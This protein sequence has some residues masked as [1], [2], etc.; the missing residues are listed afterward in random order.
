MIFF[1][2]INVRKEYVSLKA[3][4]IKFINNL[5]VEQ[6]KAVTETSSHY[7]VAEE[8]L[9]RVQP[10]IDFDQNVAC[11]DNVW[12]VIWYKTWFLVPIEF[13]F[14][15]CGKQRNWPWNGFFF[16][17]VTKTHYPYRRAYMNWLRSLLKNLKSQESLHCSLPSCSSLVLYISEWNRY[18][19]SYPLMYCTRVIHLKPK[20]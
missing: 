17:W 13:S 5:I 15:F 12:C 1:A 10:N 3:H 8:S 18:N 6:V 14:R 2:N 7:L 9:C 16:L 4:G 19:Q 20:P 11:A